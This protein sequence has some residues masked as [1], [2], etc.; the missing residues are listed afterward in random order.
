MIVRERPNAFKMLFALQG[1]VLSHILPQLLLVIGISTLVGFVDSCTSYQLPSFPVTAFSLIGLTL[2]IF[3][4]FRNNACYD[5]WWEARKQWGALIA[6]VRHLDRDS[7]LLEEGCRRRVLYRTLAFCHVLHARLRQNAFPTTILAWLP[8]QEHQ[9]VQHHRNP[10]QYILTQQQQDLIAAM[11]AGQISDIC[12]V[13]IS[14]HLTELA[15]IQAA[16]E[17]L[18]NTPLPFAYSLL[19]HRTAYLFCLLLP[20]SL[21]ST[22]GLFTPVVVGILAYTFFGLDALGT[23]LEEPFGTLKNNLPLDAMLRMMEIDLMQTL[24]AAHTP[25]PLQ[26]VDHVLT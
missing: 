12:Y 21:G 9:P 24:D 22:L 3:L 8:A 19:L 11:R 1:S 16:C 20:F 25:A 6:H 15:N 14:S 17:R 7:A 23:E 13:Q 5:R 10:G 4:G 2:S 26:P 18:L